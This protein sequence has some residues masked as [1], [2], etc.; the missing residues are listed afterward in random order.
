MSVFGIVCSCHE[1]KRGGGPRK[2]GSVHDDKRHAEIRGANEAG[3]VMLP[4][5]VRVP[6]IGQGTWNMGDDESHRQEELDTLRL[7][8]ELGLTLIDTAEMY[9]DGRA[10]SLVGE[11][12]AGLRERVFLVSKVYPHNA[13]NRRIG[14][15][16]EDTLKRLTASSLCRCF[17]PGLS[18]A[19]M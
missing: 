2:M 13:G 6:R 16:C 9:G 5:G 7:G 19:A 14:T 3:L 11:A 12:I 4:D 1:E 8:V 10:E 18:A 15:S 17:W